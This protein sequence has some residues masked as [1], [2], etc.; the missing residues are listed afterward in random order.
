M[1]YKS[2]RFF[3]VFRIALLI[4]AIL[5]CYYCFQKT[6]WQVTTLLLFVL[7]V[8]LLI[9]LIQYIDKVNRD[10][11]RFLM[12]IKHRDFSQTFVSDG[13]GKSF[14][15]LRDSF[16]VII[17]EFQKISTEK[18]ANHHYLN[19][20]VEHVP[21]GLMTIDE[22]GE[23]SL[24]NRALKEMFHFLHIKNISALD[25]IYEDASEGI[26]KLK[27][28][29]SQ[30]L[31]VNVRGENMQIAVHA[32]E[33][34]NNETVYKLLSFK[35]I[36]SELDE[37]EL[38]SWQKLISV[39]THE[40]MNSVTPISSLTGSTIKMLE[41]DSGT[42]IKEIDSET[43]HD[44]H[45]GLKTIEKRSKGL[46]HFVDVYRNLTKVPKPSM[47]EISVPELFKNL[48]TLF[49]NEFKNKGIQFNHQTTVKH[50]FADPELIEQVLI[51]LIINAI[52]AVKVSEHAVIS[53][54]AGTGTNGKLFIKVID[55][56]CGISEEKADHIFI[57]FYSTK[58]NGSGIGLS[59]SRQIMRLH[60]GSLTVKSKENEG[61]AFTLHFNI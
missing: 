9:E 10:L 33:F 59:L 57:P 44:I 34:I 55:N 46:L 12:A 1:V 39:L 17:K 37:K 29:E 49:H 6:N 23:V 30:L 7:T 11:A 3:I 35:N 15:E 60:K 18:E 53:L 2:F 25:K 42:P 32:T 14:N 48:E 26:K 28:G 47:E 41:D 50:I 20:I 45:S 8:Y 58:I 16:N 24:T 36:K 31:K 40:I 43:I 51:N 4:T 27:S 5:C 52:D 56:G 22:K 21:V 38:E 61:A 13:K 54:Q 19:T